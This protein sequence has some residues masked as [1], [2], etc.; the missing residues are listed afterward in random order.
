MGGGGG[1][2]MG[3]KKIFC[4]Y[5]N[6]RELSAMKQC[7]NC[8]TDFEFKRDSAKFCSDKC[9]AAY[10]RAHPQQMVTKLQMQ[11][12]Y[13]AVLEAVEKI[14]FAAPLNEYDGPKSPPTTQDEPLKYARH[15]PKVAVDAI[16]RKY[17]ED[18]QEC[19][20]KEEYVTWLKRLEDDDR[21]SDEQK[22]TVKKSTI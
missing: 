16:M 12:L 11:S 18:R 8:K 1:L 7:M 22:E 15:I 19:S 4:R 21:L 13:N 10:N 3:G 20:G 6:V 14:Q 2:V 17:A 5:A 9:R